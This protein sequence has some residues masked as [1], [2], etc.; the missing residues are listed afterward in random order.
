[1]TSGFSNDNA[2]KDQAFNTVYA[3]N[4]VAGSSPGHGYS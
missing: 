4:I 3:G 2:D 1:V